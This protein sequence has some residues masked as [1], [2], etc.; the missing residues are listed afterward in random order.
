MDKIIESAIYNED[1]QTILK[2]KCQWEQLRNKTILISGATGL[3][4]TPLVDMLILLNLKFSLGLKLI[5][6]SRHQKKSKYDFVQYVSHDIFTFFNYDQKIDYIIHAASNTHPLQYSKYPV[7]TIST[8]VFGTW[9]LLSL[10]EQNKDC[11]FLLVSSCEIYGNDIQ[12]LQ[13]GFSENDYGYI[14]CNNPRSCYN[15]S[16]RISETMCAAFLAERNINYVIA[17]LCRSYGPSLKKDDTK[18]LSQ[19]LYNATNKNNIILK[20]KGNQFYS[21]IYSADAASALIYLLICGENGNAYNVADNKSNITLKD[22]A[23]LI[24]S[25]SGV[26]VVYELPNEIEKKG[27]STAIRSILNS[28]KINSLGWNAQFDIE[29]GIK[30]TLELLEKK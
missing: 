12:N 20:S 7:E 29:S 25:Y 3:I 21:Y 10:A 15:E 11:R 19:F 17:R 4:G 26:K 22:L 8:N 6:I 18:A 16:K 2:F 24:A 23:E 30:R 28:G 5:L 13:N 14:D 9:N 27:Y 1:I